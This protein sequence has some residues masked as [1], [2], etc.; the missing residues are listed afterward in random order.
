[1]QNFELSAFFSKLAIKIHKYDEIAKAA[2]I[3]K[4]ALIKKLNEMQEKIKELEGGKKSKPKK[5]T[6]KKKSKKKK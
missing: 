2:M 5:K 3:D 6:V 4:N 1:M